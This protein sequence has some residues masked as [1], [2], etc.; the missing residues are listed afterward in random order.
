PALQTEK[1]STT[2]KRPL[3]HECRR[4]KPRKST[5]RRHPPRTCHIRK[6]QYI[7]RTTVPPV[8]RPTLHSLP[9]CNKNRLPAMMSTPRAHLYNNKSASSRQSGGGKTSLYCP[10]KGEAARE[11][12]GMARALAC[13]ARPRS[14]RN[15]N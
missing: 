11:L 2:S 12:S 3:C 7:P 6:R 5:T 13:R 14:A 10:P 1:K 8:P 9:L 15:G 4:R